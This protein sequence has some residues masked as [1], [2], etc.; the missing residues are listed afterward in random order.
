MPMIN[1]IE[2]EIM[3]LITSEACSEAVEN[4]I[5][6]AVKGIQDNMVVSQLPPTLRRILNMWARTNWYYNGVN[7]TW[8]Y[9]VGEAKLELC[10][11]IIVTRESRTRLYER[12]T[13]D[14]AVMGV[15]FQ[16]PD[17]NDLRREVN[18]VC[19]TMVHN[20]PTMATKL[21]E[22]ALR[23]TK[24]HDEHVMDNESEDFMW[25]HPDTGEVCYHLMHLPKPKE[26]DDEHVLSSLET[27]PCNFQHEA[28]WIC[29]I[30]LEV[31]EGTTCVRTKCNHVFHRSCFEDCKH[32]YLEQE[33]NVDKTC[34]Q[35]PICR[36]VIN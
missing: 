23:W 22:Q 3:A 30:C 31:G 4:A 32:A 11:R 5:I 12:L 14:V 34:C 35:C 15:F 33:N 17:E 7:H 24:K 18:N 10:L 36:A 26:H 16:M 21:T 9:E 20:W 13:E 8:F 19:H 1:G 29:S 28:D 27:L 2:R 6:V 25:I